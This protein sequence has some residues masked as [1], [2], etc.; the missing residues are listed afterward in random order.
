MSVS[1]V[2]ALRRKKAVTR[3][4][5]GHAFANYITVEGNMRKASR[6]GFLSNIVSLARPADLEIRTDA[7]A[8]AVDVSEKRLLR[9]ALEAPAFD[10]KGLAT[11]RAENVFV[12]KVVTLSPRG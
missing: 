10:A 9:R 5:L 6:S 2:R 3:N 7:V 11:V 4:I 8:D 1:F 12:R